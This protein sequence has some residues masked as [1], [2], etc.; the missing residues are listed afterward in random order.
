LSG[1]IAS[2]SISD[3]LWAVANPGIE[4]PRNWIGGAA[5][6][7]SANP[8]SGGNAITNL[9][10]GDKSSWE[11]DGRT[12]KSRDEEAA[13]WLTVPVKFETN[14]ESACGGA[15]KSTIVLP[16]IGVAEGTGLVGAWASLVGG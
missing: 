13:N 7:N 4:I 5:S 15:I 11:I 6:A 2:L 1:E 10:S 3:K 16:G 8:G 12:S 14:S 9:S